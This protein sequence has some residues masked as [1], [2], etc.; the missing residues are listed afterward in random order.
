[1]GSRS[2]QSQGQAVIETVVTVTLLMLFIFLSMLLV[3]KFQGRFKHDFLNN[4]EAPQQRYQAPI[5]LEF[6]KN[7]L[8]FK[9]K[10]DASVKNLKAQG[11]N[12]VNR[13]ASEDGV[14]NFLDKGPRQMLL[15]KNLGVVTCLK[16]GCNN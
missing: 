8:F 13:M 6:K 12:P 2:R 5:S 11:W 15:W 7:L 16:N 9:S 3:F 10:K 1:M 4:P 14:I